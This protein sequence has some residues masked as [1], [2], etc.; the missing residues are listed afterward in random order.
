VLA[1]ALDAEN[2][3]RELL[4]VWPN[5]PALAHRARAVVA[6]A[7]GAGDRA[8]ELLGP[9]SPTVL[10]VTAVALL[11]T[12]GCSMLLGLAGLG[13]RAP[14]GFAVLLAASPW[15]AGVGISAGGQARLR[16]PMFTA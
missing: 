3:S 5:V 9:P 6:A 16:T 7:Y 10:V 13:R 4:A 15:L 14:A 1:L 12:A 8:R 11:A 2:R